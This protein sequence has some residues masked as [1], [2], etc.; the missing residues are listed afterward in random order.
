MPGSVRYI[1]VA[2]VV[3]LT[4]FRLQFWDVLLQVLYIT[5]FVPS[6]IAEDPPLKALVKI[7]EIEEDKVFAV[8][9]K[10]TRT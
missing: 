2:P 6:N 7:A 4:L 8:P 1:V 10:F 3:K 5:S 9:L